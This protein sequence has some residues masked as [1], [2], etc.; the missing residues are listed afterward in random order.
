MIDAAS[1]YPSMSQ[2]AA[3]AEAPPPQAAAAPAA[4]PHYMREIVEPEPVN[5][6]A[7]TPEERAATLYA[8]PEVAEVEIPDNIKAERDADPLRAMYQPEKTYGDTI[9]ERTVFDDQEVAKQF[10][11]EVQRAAV[12]E[13]ANMAADVGMS[14]GDVNT[15]VT[16]LRNTREAPTEEI[17]T[18]WREQAVQRL[19]ET[20]GKDAKQAL[21]DAAK[22]VQA[23]P[24]RARMLEAKG[25]GDHPDA[26]L[27]FAKLAR[28]AKM[29]GK[30][31]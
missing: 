28:Q 7:S 23:D 11:P 6:E 3:A 30:L 29:Q 31:K 15:F 24:R 20:Y 10:K 21:A 4:P 2:P 16:V 19:N 12:K 5:L 13:L 27:L 18:Q 22:F 9:N 17:R 8:K 14:N 25:A 26:V 1:L